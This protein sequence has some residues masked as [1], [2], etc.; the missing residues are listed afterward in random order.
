MRPEIPG[1][2]TFPV[3]KR[4]LADVLIVSDDEILQAVAF[5]LQRLKLVVEPTG[6]VPLAALM[7]GRLPPQYQNVGIILSGG[8]LDPSLL[9][10]LPLA[11]TP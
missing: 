2:L 1:T 5:C 8:N 4:H 6:A 11:L 9:A 7:A 3:I 10:R